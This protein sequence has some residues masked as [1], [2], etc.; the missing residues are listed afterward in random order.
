MCFPCFFLHYIYSLIFPA[1]PRS[2]NWFCRCRWILCS[3][4]CQSTKFHRFSQQSASQRRFMNYYETP[5]FKTAEFACK[6][7][8]RVQVPFLLLLSD[9]AL[10]PL[11]Q[12]IGS[13]TFLNAEVCVGDAF[14]AISELLAS[15]LHPTPDFW[16]CRKQMR[17]TWTISC[18]AMTQNNTIKTRNMKEL[19][20]EGFNVWLAVWR[21]ERSPAM[22]G[23]FS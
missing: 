3:P 4:P 2:L 16:G 19:N 12:P 11:T 15:L 23:I 10:W 9:C 20:G 5:V 6:V 7:S 18:S 13:S 8:W 14:V 22:S 21:G 1:D 17:T